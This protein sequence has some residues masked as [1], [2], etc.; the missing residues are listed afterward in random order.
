MTAEVVGDDPGDAYAGSPCGLL[1]LRASDGLVVE[2][3]E[4]LLSWIGR[5]RQEVVGAVTLPEL[6]SLGGRMFWETHLSP[7]LRTEGRVDEVALDLAVAAGRLPVLLSASY[8]VPAGGGGTGAPSAASAPSVGLIRVALASAFERSRYEHDLLAAR[9]DAERTGSRLA[10]LQD[11]AGALAVADGVEPVVR[12]LVDATVGPTGAGSGSVWLTEPGTDRLVAHTSAGEAPGTVG[13]PAA[14]SV[15]GA[16]ASTVGGRVVVP[17]RGRTTLQG[18]LSLAPDTGLDAEP[19]DLDM[20]TAVGLQVGLA[21]ERVRLFEQAAHVAR[22]LQES[23]L[24]GEPPADRRFG[25][26]SAYRPGVAGLQVGGDWYDTFLAEEDVLAVAVGDVVGRGLGAASAMGQLRSAVRAIAGEDVGPARLLSRL[27]RFVDPIESARMATMAYGELDL[28][29]GLLRYACAGHLPPVLLPE[30]G[31]PMLLWGGRSTPLAA[32]GLGAARDEAQV[33]LRPG[34]RI[35]L[36]TDG[37]VERRGR[38]LDESLE[39]LCRAVAEHATA[40]LPEVVSALTT[41]LLQDEEH[42][43]DVCA[44]LLLWSGPDRFERWIGADLAELGALRG[45]F[46]SWLTGVGVDEVTCDDLV[47]ACSEA[48]ANAAEHGIG[49]RAG[50][51]V[52]MTATRRPAADG[53]GGSLVL[54]VYSDG[55][56]VDRG[57]SSDGERG[58]GLLIITA[59]VDDVEIRTGR[60]QGTTV[61]MER[62]LISAL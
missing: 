16:D 46:A 33:Q 1:S 10:T 61:V 26:A 60:G 3:N 25:S 5:T 32:Y 11:V 38:T 62:A 52:R 51:H 28:G 59:L 44:L 34:D 17:L 12:A 20:L 23:L 54:E 4:T 22:T 49:L 48:V 15:T 36:Y 18:A 53:R 14:A 8:A 7:V 42:R 31:S 43:D 13:P 27:D 45:E 39:L 9:H 40:P 56:W 50:G 58:R 35:L 55:E 29:T 6:L 2:A 21:L 57:A 24:A 41:T 47:L 37:L 19:L 30:S